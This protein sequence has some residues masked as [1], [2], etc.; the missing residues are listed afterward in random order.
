VSIGIEVEHGLCAPGDKAGK[1][2]ESL[3]DD[4]LFLG[5]E[6]TGGDVVEL[7]ERT[8]LR[9]RTRAIKRVDTDE[10]TQGAVARS[11][12]RIQ[13]ETSGCAEAVIVALA[14]VTISR[15]QGPP[16]AGCQKR[17]GAQP[18]VNATGDSSL[19]KPAALL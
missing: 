7:V 17:N 13:F 19:K 5:R 18:G 8:R 9:G 16:A 14:G 3:I 1:L 6:R 12:A 15:C 10:G 2:N 11:C 4:R